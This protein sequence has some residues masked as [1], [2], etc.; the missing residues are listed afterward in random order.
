MQT[1][2]IE[3]KKA[4]ITGGSR[5]IGRGIARKL[6]DAG[7][8]IAFTYNS[9]LDEAKAVKAENEGKGQRCFFYQASLQNPDVAEPTTAKA[10]EDLGGIDLLVCN[11][12]LTRFNNLL[13]LEGTLIDFVY[14]LNYR[15]YLMCA[16]VAAN[17][18]VS[19]GVKGNIIFIASTRGFRAYPEDAIYGGLK[20][21]LIR[22]TES[23][24][25]DMAPHGIRVNCVA[26]GAT[27]TRG[28]FTPEELS[29]GFGEK[30]PL[31]RKGTPDEIGCL[32]RFIASDEAAY[33]TGN[34]VKL[35]G[36]L[37]LPGIPERMGTLPLG[38]VQ[39]PRDAIL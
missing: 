27:A 8:D 20:A 36:G 32:V 11:A 24:A 3:N 15:S 13:H 16:K 23:I 33:M 21:A 19:R 30:I 26:P 10:I 39:K 28:S 9:Q 6:S 17:D 38:M 35:D 31:K 1:Q 2:P 37:I 7:Y 29:S 14:N 18:M 5:G 22:S 12:G 4:F 34:T 25:L